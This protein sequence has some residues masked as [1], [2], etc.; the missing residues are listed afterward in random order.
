MNKK[1]AAKGGRFRGFT[2][3]R[4]LAEALFLVLFIV[5]SAMR[6]INL[7]MGVFLIGVGLSVLFGRIYCGWACP[8][9]TLMRPIA[10]VY[11]KLGIKRIPGPGLLKNSFVRYGLLAATLVAMMLIKR[12]GSGFPLLPAVVALSLLVSLVFEESFW[13]AHLCPYGTILN[14][15]SRFARWGVRIAPSA[16]VACGQCLKACPAEAIRTDEDRKRFVVARDCLVCGAC[17]NPCPTN[18]IDYGWLEQASKE[19]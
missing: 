17:F 14:L 9:A 11:K 2:V 10:F 7:W 16:C 19:D 15:T 3:G 6:K 5:L 8:M 1:N 18:T 12:S 4:M 13:H